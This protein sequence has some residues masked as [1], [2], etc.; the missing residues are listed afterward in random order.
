MY[1][2]VDCIAVAFVPLLTCGR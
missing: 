1:I 2:F